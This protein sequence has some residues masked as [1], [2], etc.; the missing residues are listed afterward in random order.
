M[1]YNT[2]WCCDWQ[3]LRIMSRLIVQMMTC[4]FT[5]VRRYNQTESDSSGGFP[6][7]NTPPCKVYGPA[8]FPRC[9]MFWL[10]S[11][12]PTPIEF[13]LNFVKVPGRQSAP[14]GPVP[15]RGCAELKPHCSR[16]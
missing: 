5:L 16:I 1:P 9:G 2:G 15:S 10:K 4:L 6:T 11:V 8:A 3:G 12:A 7:Y 13:L 14:H